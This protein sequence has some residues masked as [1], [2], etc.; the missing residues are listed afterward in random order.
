MLIP[1]GTPCDRAKGRSRGMK[2]RFGYVLVGLAFSCGL[3]VTPSNGQICAGDCNGNGQ[4]FLGEVQTA[5]NVFLG[6]AQLQACEEAD[7]TPDGEVTLGEVQAVFV[8]FLGAC[9]PPSPTPTLTR[10]PPPTATTIPVG[11]DPLSVSGTCR[12]PA[13]RIGDGL[14]NC[15]TGTQITVSFCGDTRSC[16][17]SNQSK[18][19]LGAAFVSD[20]GSFAVSVNREAAQSAL[21]IVEAGVSDAV[22]YRTITFGPLEAQSSSRQTTLRSS[23]ASLETDVGD[24]DPTSEASSRL[25]N[26]SVLNVVLLS[27][28]CRSN[29]NSES[30]EFD[31]C[32]PGSIFRV[33]CGGG[34]S[35]MPGTVLGKGIVLPDESDVSVASAGPVPLH[36]IA[37]IEGIDGTVRMY[38]YVRTLELLE[39]TIGTLEDAVDAAIERAGVEFGG[40]TPAEAADV[41]T[42]T[43]ANDVEVQR[44]LNPEP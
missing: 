44:I 42:D 15:E 29:T 25:A 16:R 40:R 10:T 5:F 27:P 32:Q 37:E 1:A 11:P 13:A 28:C 23:T 3:C 30:C 38:D 39:P 34:G 43:A 14:R 6:D 18:V 17:Q 31:L 36:V 33:L 22:I 20:G 7:T 9:A 4:V 26:D 12:L 8:A 19:P 21:L 24:V 2:M 41:A 35:C